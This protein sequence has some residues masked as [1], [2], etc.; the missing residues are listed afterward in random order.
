MISDKRRSRSRGSH[1]ITRDG[2]GSTG[3]AQS[4]GDALNAAGG[5]VYATYLQDDRLRIWSWPKASVPADLTSGSPNPE[6]WGT[7]SSD[8]KTSNGGCSVGDN[9]Q[10]QTIIINTDFCGSMIDDG[11]WKAVTSCS[12]VES[13]CA[14]F[15]AG[16][17]DAFKDA[18]WLFNSIKLYEST[19]TDNKVSEDG[20]CGGTT[21]QTCLGSEFGD[22]CSQYGY[23]GASDLY[24][25]TGCQPGF[26]TCS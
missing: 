22:C 8:F 6:T 1:Y 14:A 24:C 11:T 18:Y 16:H 26:G 4:Y 9:F 17:P 5:G 19:G 13:T 23:C 25:G 15:A 3:N 7:A 2:C 12:S 10:E 21:V 20:N